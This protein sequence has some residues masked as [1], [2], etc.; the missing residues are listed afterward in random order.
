MQLEL[1][2][3]DIC[4]RCIRARGVMTAVVE[5]LGDDQV[6]VAFLDV[7]ENLDHAVETGVLVTPA[8]AVNGKLM[9]SPLP[10]RDRILRSLRTE[11][12]K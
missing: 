3:A 10:D 6:E 2:T 11:L 7:V 1:F 9:F 4:S 8:L 5:E 12:T